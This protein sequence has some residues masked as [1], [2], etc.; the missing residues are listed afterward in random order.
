MPT[1]KGAEDQLIEPKFLDSMSTEGS[2][3]SSSALSSPRMPPP[4]QTLAEVSMQHLGGVAVRSAG[5]DGQ[6]KRTLRLSAANLRHHDLFMPKPK[7]PPIA[8][9]ARL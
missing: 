2:E 1:Q 6:E 8:R 5:E 3:P 9:Q 7:G 4:A